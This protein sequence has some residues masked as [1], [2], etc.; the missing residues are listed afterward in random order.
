MR[1]EINPFFGFKQ[2]SIDTPSKYSGG[3]LRIVELEFGSKQYVEAAVQNVVDYPNS[4][5]RCESLSKKCATPISVGYCP[6]LALGEL[7]PEDTAYFHSLVGDLR[8]IV[9]LGRIDINVGV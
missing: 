9:D 8:W 1:N 7:Q 5:K 2:D 3:K 6:G 4:K